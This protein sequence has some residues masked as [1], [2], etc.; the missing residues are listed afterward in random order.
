MFIDNI[1]FFSFTTNKTIALIVLF[2]II[3]IIYSNFNSYI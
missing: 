3:E 1:S 2:T